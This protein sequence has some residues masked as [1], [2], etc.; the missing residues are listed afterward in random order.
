MLINITG[1]KCVGIE[2]MPVTVEVDIARGIGIHLVGLADIAVKESL[3]R[4]ITALQSL[5]F[6]I[7][8]KKIVINLAPA[9]MRKNGSGYDLPIALGII[10]ASGQ[11]S[12]PGLGK[13]LIM[14]E[15]GLDGSVREVP[16]ALPFAELSIRL[17]FEG[18]ILPFN[19][20]L[21]AV[22]YKNAKIY[23]V[24]N[25][26]DVLRII[27]EQEDASDL[28]IWNNKAYLDSISAP[29]LSPEYMDFADIIGQEG[30]KRGAEIAVAGGHNL[31]MVGPPGSGKSSLAKA[32]AGILPP[33]TTDEALVTSKLYSISGRGSQAL[34][35]IR[36]RPFRAPH[37][38]ASLAAIVGGGN[39][40]NILPG[41]VSLAHNG[42]LFLDELAQMPK[43][44]IE[45]LRGPI[46][47]RHVTIS[48]LR[49]K[50][51][52]PSS[53]M[54]V[55]A[56]NPC[57]CGYYGEGDRCTC[58]VGQRV[59]YLSK[60]SGPI[61]DRIDIHLWLHPVE[62]RKLVNRIKGESSAS[63]A[64]RVL[65]AR[66]I[67]TERFRSENIFTNAEMSSRQIEKYC[68]LS[69]ECK[70]LLEKLIRR[71]GLSARAFSRIIKV[72]RTIADLDSSKGI[73]PRH[74]TEAAGYRFLDKRDIGQ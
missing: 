31:I 12:T 50:I 20:A 61:M 4:T 36:A 18:C 23:G 59:G 15:L 37:Y 21:E 17:G 16:G 51:E 5:N 9:D 13:Y 55:A 19:S 6:N 73:E 56:T 14:G 69:D 7:P 74:I 8:G 24:R 10:A 40:D 65:E 38:S 47:D 63:V 67:Q 35:L 60:L 41:E 48:R 64:K 30:A 62:T 34:G 49:S 70:E 72:A 27:E 42:V 66:K 26:V 1:A 54:L 58:S 39:G 32:I 44:V 28:L 71:L 52:Y 57:P 53:F 45:A 22:E 11:R 3:L 46:E 33:M 68:P 25:L 43:S 29:K 2:A